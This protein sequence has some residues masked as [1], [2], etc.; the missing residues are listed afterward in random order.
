MRR[1]YTP[2]TQ[3]KL[4]YISNSILPAIA[5]NTGTFRGI[6]KVK[7]NKGCTNKY[8]SFVSH[9]CMNKCVLTHPY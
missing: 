5:G 6:T 8:C 3:R 1:H 9:C 2:S 7:K 4:C